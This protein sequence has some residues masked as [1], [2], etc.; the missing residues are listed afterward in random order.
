MSLTQES[1][2]YLY[3]DQG[4]GS[5]DIVKINAGYTKFDNKI[6]KG[7]SSWIPMNITQTCAMKHHH[8]YFINFNYL[9]LLIII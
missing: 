9:N 7:Y 4:E 6:P 3:V 5:G 2:W 1:Y 8:R